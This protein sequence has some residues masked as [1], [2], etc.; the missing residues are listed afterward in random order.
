MEALHYQLIYKLVRQKRI[1]MQQ[2]YGL[3]NINGIVIKDD[4]QIEI[5]YNKGIV[6]TYLVLKNKTTLKHRIR[7][8]KKYKLY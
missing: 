1:K 7:F 4:G 8:N 6:T 2:V 3:D 5:K